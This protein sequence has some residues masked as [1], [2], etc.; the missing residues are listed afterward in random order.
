VKVNGKFY[1]ASGGLVATDYGVGMLTGLMPQQQVPFDIEITNAPASIVRY[2]LNVVWNNLCSN[3]RLV[4]V[5]SQNIRDNHGAEIFGEVRNDTAAT[6]G[7]V[8]VAVSFYDAA[9]NLWD[10][11]V[12]FATDRSLGSGQTTTYRINTGK[13]DLLTL[14][15]MVQG[16]GSAP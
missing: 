3:Y 8:T 6:L 2:E 16:E 14:P 11:D 1:D 13:L 9:G 12:S 5:V 4:T 15:Y 10:A 7:V